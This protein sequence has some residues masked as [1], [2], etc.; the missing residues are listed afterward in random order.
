MH[1]SRPEKAL[2][3]AQ[4]DPNY[5]PDKIFLAPNYEMLELLNETTEIFLTRS[6]NLFHLLT[7]S[8]EIAAP[9]LYRDFQKTTA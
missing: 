9:F 4:C 8:S 3:E 6:K 5:H 7:F 2:T 1:L